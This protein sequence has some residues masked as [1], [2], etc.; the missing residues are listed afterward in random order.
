MY[1]D[2][3]LEPVVYFF[4]L[5]IFRYDFKKCLLFDDRLYIL[6][7]KDLQI[8][9]WLILFFYHLPSRFL[10]RTGL[11]SL[12]CFYLGLTNF[13]QDAH[14]AVYLFFG[15]IGDSLHFCNPLQ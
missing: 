1:D 12:N 6:F 2:I 14:A 7:F 10:L 4:N 8:D 11:K 5:G 9:P 13:K 15:L 3:Y